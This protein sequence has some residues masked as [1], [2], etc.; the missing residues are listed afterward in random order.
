M[1]FKESAEKSRAKLAGEA[2]TLTV[3]IETMVVSLHSDGTFLDGAHPPHVR[4][5][6]DNA[7]RV[8][9][10]MLIAKAVKS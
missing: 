2:V 1:N 7:M 9:A 5:R 8:A 3:A 10:A 6:I 4:A